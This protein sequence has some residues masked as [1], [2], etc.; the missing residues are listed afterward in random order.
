MPLLIVI[1]G[2][3]GTG[4]DAV[5][6]RM[7]ELGHPFHYTVTATTRNQRPEER[8]GK[9]YYF[10]PETKFQE[11][12]QQDELLEWAKVY[13][14]WYGVPKLPVKQALA[15]GQDVII[16]V[17]VQGAATIRNLLPGAVLIFLVP[18]SMEELE[19]R[20][21]R[22]QTESA[23]DLELRMRTAQEEMNSLPLFDYVVVN[24]HGKVDTTIYQ[25]N[26]IVTA[27]KCRV[28]PRMV[29]LD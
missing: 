7:K 1:S 16:K 17:D 28:K 13:G 10:V 12:V 3:S 26:A 15:E 6:S 5:I 9:D 21:R 25:I 14:N 24:H 11:M 4:K 2:L 19:K 27:E 8:E 20:L 22:R 18:P 29:K 23:A